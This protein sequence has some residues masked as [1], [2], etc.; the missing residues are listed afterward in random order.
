MFKQTFMLHTIQNKRRSSLHYINDKTLALTSN[1]LLVH[2][3]F[4]H[5]YKL[6]HSIRLLAKYKRVSDKD[7]Y[8]MNNYTYK[9]QNIK[10]FS[11]ACTPHHKKT[12]R[13]ASK[14]KD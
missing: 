3:A 8:T 11:C 9:V 12:E 5:S 10:D 1:I 2:C 14:V 13:V 4:V 6:H 7:K